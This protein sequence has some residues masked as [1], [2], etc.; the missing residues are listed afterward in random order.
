MTIG[1]SPQGVQASH[2]AVGLTH[3]LGAVRSRPMPTA[4]AVT[5]SPFVPRSAR[6]PYSHVEN[7]TRTQL[8]KVGLTALRAMVDVEPYGSNDLGGDPLDN[9]PPSLW[10]ASPSED[11]DPEG[12][13]N[14]SSK[15]KKKKRNSRRQ[16]R[17][18]FKEAKAITTTKIVVNLPGF[19]AKD[20]SDFAESVGPFLTMTGRTQASGRVKGYLVLQ[21]CKT[22]YLEKQVMQIVTKSATFPDVLVA[23]ERQYPSYETDLSIQ[24]E[25]KNLAML[26]NNL[27]P[28]RILNYWPTS[29][30]GRGD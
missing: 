26:P 17:R 20:L 10:S 23:L 1:A 24:I 29:A 19:T 2:L 15:R 9:E 6:P 4:A 22:K 8:D 27:K 5:K 7:S 25:N 3:T 12:P 30:T 11:G 14:Q 28:A 18:R 13:E 21:C 16:Q